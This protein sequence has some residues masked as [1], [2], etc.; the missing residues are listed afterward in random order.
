MSDYEDFNG[1]I[2]Q[3]SGENHIH[4]DCFDVMRYPTAL[5][6]IAEKKES[7]GVLAFKK[8]WT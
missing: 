4:K 5:L 8:C 2:I 3:R 1:C 7:R 6:S